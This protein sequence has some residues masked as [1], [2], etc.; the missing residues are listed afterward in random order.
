MNAADIKQ[1]TD[2]EWS[3]Y[4]VDYRTVASERK[5]PDV[6]TPDYQN[7]MVLRSPET[8]ELIGMVDY[9][10]NGRRDYW[11]FLNRVASKIVCGVNAK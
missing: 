9:F 8:N 3:T 1:V 10:E 7:S 2:D 4:C 5:Y 11:I 6:E